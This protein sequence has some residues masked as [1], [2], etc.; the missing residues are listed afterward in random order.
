[1]KIRY[2]MGLRHPVPS[3]GVLSTQSFWLSSEHSDDNILKKTVLVAFVVG[4]VP[5]DRVRSTALSLI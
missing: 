1:M 5:L 4:A 2:P 3:C